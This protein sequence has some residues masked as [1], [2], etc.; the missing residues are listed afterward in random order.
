MILRIHISFGLQERLSQLTFAKRFCQTA[1][2][3][4]RKYLMAEGMSLLFSILQPLFS[5]SFVCF[6]LFLFVLL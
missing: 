3:R 4:K 5:F 6:T 2:S 1:G